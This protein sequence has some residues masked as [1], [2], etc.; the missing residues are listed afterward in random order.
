MKIEDEVGS[1]GNEYPIG[2]LEAWIESES[3]MKYNI[4][5]HLAPPEHRAL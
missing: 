1:V 3:V 2:A 5:P 4:L